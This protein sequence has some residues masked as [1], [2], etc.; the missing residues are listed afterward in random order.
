MTLNTDSTISNPSPA[1]LPRRHAWRR[2]LVPAIQIGI[3][4]AILAWLL[5]DPGLLQQMGQ[6]LGQARW[7]WLALGALI[8]IAWNL[9]A[10]FRWNIFLKMQGIDIGYR[11]TVCIYF[12]SMFFTLVLPGAMSADAVRL[13]Y[14]FRE[15]PMHKTG[16]LLSVIF[17]HFAGLIAL[18]GI[19]TLFTF[20]RQDWFAQSPLTSGTLYFLMYAFG[21]TIF[22]LI[23]TWLAVITGFIH[24]MPRFT[25][26]RKQLI[27]WGIS[28]SL[29]VRYWRLSLAGIG[30]S[31]LST[32]GF[33]TTFWCAARAFS[34]DA[35]LLDI[36]S[37]MPVIDLVSALPITVSGL[38][39]REMM[40]EEMLETLA[41]VPS[42]VALLISLV[43]FGC[44]V[45]WYLAG[46]ILFPL[47]R[48]S[49]AKKRPRVFRDLAG[50]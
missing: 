3:T 35:T 46:G 1:T 43:G 10:A 30:A 5:S 45:V 27:D 15:R 44:S 38:G 29:F 42:D 33:F 41:G 48:S 24:T 26:F 20:T 28:F 37:V 49:G 25:P 12:I 34:S 14:I 39:V 40:F 36:L 19:A 11:R 21:G 6:T 17:D 32:L 16:A 18:M 8:G 9:A 50:D 2:W 13:F 47:Y 4:I 31:F 22:M 23:A 7:R